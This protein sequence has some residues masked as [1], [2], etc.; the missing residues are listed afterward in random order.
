M[1]DLT[2]FQMVSLLVVLTACL[3]VG[4]WADLSA[5]LMVAQTADL[6]VYC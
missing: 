1:A 4:H 3:W 6:M 5:V 2:A